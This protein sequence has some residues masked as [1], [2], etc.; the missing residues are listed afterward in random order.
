MN[1]PIDWTQELIDCDNDSIEV[2]F[3]RYAQDRLDEEEEDKKDKLKRELDALIRT[4]PYIPTCQVGTCN[5]LFVPSDGACFWYALVVCLYAQFMRSIGDVKELRDAVYEEMNSNPLK[6]K[7]LFE[8]EPA[9]KQGAHECAD[10]HQYCDMAV[11]N[12]RL[13]ALE[14]VMIAAS[15]VI[16]RPMEVLNI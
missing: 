5:V 13:Y 10:I 4:L 7:D 6:F 9:F 1:A 8:E 12:P 3:R 15:S 11:A 2:E 16:Q 14:I